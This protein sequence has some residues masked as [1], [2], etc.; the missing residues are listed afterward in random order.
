MTKSPLP[1]TDA[2]EVLRQ[3]LQPLVQVVG[4]HPSPQPGKSLPS[5]AEK[6]PM[7]AIAQSIPAAG[8]SVSE[9]MAAMPAPAA[10]PLSV[11]PSR[12]PLRLGPARLTPARRERAFTVEVPPELRRAVRLRAAEDGI[13]ERVLVL[14]A[15]RA[16]G[17]PVAEGDLVDRRQFNGARR[18]EP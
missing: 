9:S 18:H 1:D 14:R 15:L 7:T 2:D 10:A 8:S 13:T 17:L 12:S 6:A 5:A 11:A 4:A 3:T 16:Y